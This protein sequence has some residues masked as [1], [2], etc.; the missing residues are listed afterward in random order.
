[1][2]HLNYYSLFKS[3]IFASRTNIFTKMC[4]VFKVSYM[5]LLPLVVPEQ[6][7]DFF[8]FV[9]HWMRKSESIVAK[10]FRLLVQLC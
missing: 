2:Q 3:V 10:C 7:G 6:R 8:V 4:L 9:K 1:M 5:I